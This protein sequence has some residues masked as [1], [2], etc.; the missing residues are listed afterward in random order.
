MGPN[1]VG[2]STLLRILAGEEVPDDGIVRR[3]GMVGY[4]PQL[5]DAED[6]RL[7]VRQTVRER[8]G[9]ASASRA[10]EHW[11]VALAAGDLHAVDAHADALEHWLALGGADVDARLGAALADLGLD[12][13]F[14]ERPL[15]TLSGGQ[16]ARA[17]LAALQVTR[18]DVVLLDEPTNHLDADGL[19]RLAALLAVRAGGVVLVSHDRTLLADTVTEVV[20]LDGHTGQAEH[21]RGGWDVY[22]SE[23]E[24]ARE[25]AL[26]E[27]QHAL[28]RRAQLIAAERET[29]RRAAASVN[30]A[31][32]RPHDNDKHSRE[33]VTMRA[34]GMAGR[35]R[36]MGGRARRIDVPDAP[37]EHPVLRLHLT[38]AERRGTRSWRW[39]A[40]S[41]AAMTGRSGHLT[42]RWRT[43][44]ECSSAARTGAASPRCFRR[45]PAKFL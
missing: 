2:K 40:W 28:E 30:R 43:A 18:F 35:A 36:K 44:S 19:R 17:G 5:A 38:P 32:A 11:T 27:R 26:A 21:Y 22:E 33:W 13:G 4:L 39:T 41:C 20:E 9:V 16:A 15:N 14:L 23:R 45:S 29:R 8:V 6:R 31:R 42:S 7:T 24:A 3:F 12:P 34:Q 25:R 1:G 10:L 37:W